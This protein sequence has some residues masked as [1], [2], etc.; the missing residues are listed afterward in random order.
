MPDQVCESVKKQRTAKILEIGNK[1]ECAFVQKMI[2]TQCSVLFEE[3]V[4]DNLSEG[5]SGQYVRVRA[6]GRPGEICNVQILRTEGALALGEVIDQ[7][8]K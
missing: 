7:E 6:N 5:Y 1:L 3:K 8:V 2:G 4:G